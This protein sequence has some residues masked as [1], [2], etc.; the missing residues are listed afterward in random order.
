MIHI[1]N[2]AFLFP[3]INVLHEKFY[4]QKTIIVLI[5]FTFSISIEVKKYMCLFMAAMVS[6][7]VNL[8]IEATLLWHFH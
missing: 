3:S 7:G 6:N 1:L 8:S 2:E 4:L 5:D